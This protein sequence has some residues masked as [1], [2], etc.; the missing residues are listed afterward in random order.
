MQISDVSEQMTRLW[1]AQLYKEHQ[2]IAWYHR[3]SL[4]PVVIRIV[5]MSANWGQWDPF[6]RTIS[7]SEKLI[8]E[9]SWDVVLEILITDCP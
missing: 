9:H 4:K 8:R 5:D 2:E 3:V 6:L 1:I 7:L